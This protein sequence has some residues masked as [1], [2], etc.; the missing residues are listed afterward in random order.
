MRQTHGMVKYTMAANAPARADKKARPYRA[1]AKPVN[2]AK[3]AKAACPTRAPRST[4]PMR[5]MPANAHISCWK[6]KFV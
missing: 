5:C 2:G 1:S 4:S 3:H 6:G